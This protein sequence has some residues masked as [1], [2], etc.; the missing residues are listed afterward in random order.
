ATPWSKVTIGALP[1]TR[2]PS[3]SSLLL[4]AANGRVEATVSEPAALRRKRRREMRWD[5]GDGRGKALRLGRAP[6]VGGAR[7]KPVNA[8]RAEARTRL[9]TC[10]LKL[11]PMNP[12]LDALQ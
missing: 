7:Y 4:Q 10:L 11:R 2:L 9:V 3:S 8:G 12:R 1:P 5:M 6:S